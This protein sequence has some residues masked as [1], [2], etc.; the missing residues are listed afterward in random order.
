MVLPVSFSRNAF[1]GILVFSGTEANRVKIDLISTGNQTSKR[2]RQIHNCLDGEALLDGIIRLKPV[3]HEV[4]KGDCLCCTNDSPDPPVDSAESWSSY[5]VPI[6]RRC[7]QAVG[8][9]MKSAKECETKCLSLQHSPSPK[10]KH[11]TLPLYAKGQ[12]CMGTNQRLVRENGSQRGSYRRGLN[13]V[14]K[15]FGR[16]GNCTAGIAYNKELER[17]QKVQAVLER[18]LTQEITCPSLRP[19]PVDPQEQDCICCLEGFS[20]RSTDDWSSK[21]GKI[22]EFC[23]KAKASPVKSP[24]VCK[25]I[26]SQNSCCRRSET[27]MGYQ[28]SSYAN[29]NKCLGKSFITACRSDALYEDKS[30]AAKSQLQLIRAEN[31][32]MVQQLL[33]A[34]AVGDVLPSALRL[35]Q[36]ERGT[37]PEEERDTASVMPGHMAT[38]TKTKIASPMETLERNERPERPKRPARGRR[39]HRNK[40]SKEPRPADVESGTREKAEDEEFDAYVA[41]ESVA[42]N[43]GEAAVE[44]N[45]DD[46]GDVPDAQRPADVESETTE[47]AEDEEGFYAHVAE[48]SVRNDQ[49]K[50]R[51][52]RSK[53][54]RQYRKKGSKE[55]RPS[56][57]TSKKRP[58]RPTSTK[59]KR[60][61][62]TNRSSRHRQSKKDSARPSAEL[63]A[64]E[65]ALFEA[66]LHGKMTPNTK[67]ELHG[68]D[69]QED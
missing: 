36:S 53:R 45:T 17:M 7:M 46:T 9:L 20:L 58:A 44:S 12:H 42:A 61:G 3:P 52:R 10:F 28:W 64:D 49:K 24:S 29:Q 26:C 43:A 39:Q 2:S 48:T 32:G 11:Y 34:R 60:S 15:F 4:E 1:F 25:V 6:F 14:A 13:K 27:Q 5:K 55:P 56:S 66:E 67:A 31:K 63:N 38:P 33:A 18:E 40:G 62:R 23:F 54:R 50:G 30:L 51:I 65:D 19:L 8:G 22:L 57:Q 21:R 69:V 37:R 41:D 68:E 35:S 47:K 59:K 16:T